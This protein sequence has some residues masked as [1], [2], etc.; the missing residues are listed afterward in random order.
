MSEERRA[1]IERVTKETKITGTVNLMVAAI[2]K[3]PPA[4]AFSTI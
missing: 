1:R 2:T 3:W 4:L